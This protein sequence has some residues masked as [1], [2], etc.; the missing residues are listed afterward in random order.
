MIYTVRSSITIVCLP[1]MY[2][3]YRVCV[4]ALVGPVGPCSGLYP[5]PWLGHDGQGL[6]GPH[7]KLRGAVESVS[8]IFY[9]FQHTYIHMLVY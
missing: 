6:H 7:A 4:C 9:Y 1:G 8:F 2:C 3:I 5:I